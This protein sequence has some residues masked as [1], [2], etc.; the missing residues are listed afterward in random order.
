[1]DDV[2]FDLVRFVTAQRHRLR[3]R[4]P[5]SSGRAARPATGSGS[6]SR[7]SRGLGQSEFARVYGIASLDEARA[8]LAHPVL[9]PRIRECASVIA[10]SGT[11]TADDYLRLA[12]TT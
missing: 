9:G 12:R 2:E 8:Y 3:A 5:R 7:S 11:A 1:M 4:A 6:C 10:A